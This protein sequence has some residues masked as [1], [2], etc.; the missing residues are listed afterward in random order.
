M[1]LY[2]SGDDDAIASFI[3]A[4]FN[5]QAEIL[6]AATSELNQ[7][8]VEDIFANWATATGVLSLDDFRRCEFNSSLV[9]RISYECHQSI[10]D[11]FAKR[12]IVRDEQNRLKRLNLLYISERTYILTFLIHT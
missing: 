11:K 12:F 4:V 2:T 10:T 9:S 3:T 6:N 1:K 5:G 8:E 7:A